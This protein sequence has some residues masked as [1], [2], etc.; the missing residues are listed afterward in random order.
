[1]NESDIQKVIKALSLMIEKPEYSNMKIAEEINI[2]APTLSK[3]LK[4]ARELGYYKSKIFLDIPKKY[5]H[6]LPSKITDSLQKKL[7]NKY[8]DSF[9]KNI[10]VVN[11][12]SKYEEAAEI[13]EKILLYSMPENCTAKHNILVSWGYT[14]QSVIKCINPREVINEDIKFQIF[15]LVGDFPIISDHEISDSSTSNDIGAAVNKYL[16]YQKVSANSNASILSKK[17]DSDQWAINSTGLIYLPDDGN[18]SSDNIIKQASYFLTR[19]FTLNY[20]YGDLITTKSDDGMS[21]GKKRGAINY[22]DTFITSLG[23]DP[24]EYSESMIGT[25]GESSKPEGFFGNIAGIEFNI[26]GEELRLPNRRVVGFCLDVLKNI[27]MRHLG[28]LHDPLKEKVHG[29]GLV[30]LSFFDKQSK[31]AGTSQQLH[32]KAAFTNFIVNSQLA[33]TII[34]DKRMAEAVL[35]LK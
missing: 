1:M 3:L 7:I 15:P 9:V 34:I 20:L 25:L 28:T 30:L 27:V 18:S 8:K 24:P 22:I 31:D 32:N 14:V 4:E 12:H 17:L 2:P 29:G 10:Y 13:I 16:E 21:D 19:D 5:D 33:N 23:C 11:N 35:A 6:Y 26:E